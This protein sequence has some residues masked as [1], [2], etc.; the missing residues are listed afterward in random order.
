[1]G[2]VTVI[3]SSVKE[4]GKSVVAANLAYTLARD[5]RKSTLLI[6][7]DLK[8]PTIHHYFGI[9][10]S[11]GLRDVL[12][13]TQSLEC[14]LQQEGEFPLWILP[15]GVG[16]GRTVDD[17]SRIN[18]IAG[19]LGDLKNRYDYIIIDAPPVLPLADMHVI[20]SMA[21]T[22]AF[23]IRAG[24]T[25]RNVVESALRTLGEAHNNTCIILN[26]LEA[27]GAPYYMQQGYE[28]VL[29]GKKHSYQ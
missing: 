9:P 12:Q 28:Y 5:M 21:D 25:P 3:T 15:S 20:G 19:M 22:V 26:E 6:D 7:G 1:M 16:R 24:L 13:G 27:R 18:Q 17:L 4:E 10:Q 11:P 2:K 14:C 23:V 8:S 29:E